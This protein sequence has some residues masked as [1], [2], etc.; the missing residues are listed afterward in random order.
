MDPKKTLVSQFAE[1]GL[2]ISLSIF[3]LTAFFSLLL[4][5]GYPL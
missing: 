5:T 3:L 2:P 1:M 4:A